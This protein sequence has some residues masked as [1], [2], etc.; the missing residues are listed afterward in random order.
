MNNTP[1]TIR[2]AG[3]AADGSVISVVVVDT[4]AVNYEDWLIQNVEALRAQFPGGMYF[5]PDEEHFVEHG[6]RRVDNAWQPPITPRDVLMDQANQSI[7]RVFNSGLNFRGKQLS[8][9]VVSQ[10]S[11]H[12]IYTIRNTYPNYPI[13]WPNIDDTDFVELTNAE[14]V[15]ELYETMTAHIITTRNTGAQTKKDIP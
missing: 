11:A 3:L 5:L 13:L 15:A 6:W 2:V 7:A 8:L 1:S 4:I 14:D 12:G 9:S 10:V